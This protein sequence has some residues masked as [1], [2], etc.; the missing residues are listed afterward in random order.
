MPTPLSDGEF[1]EA[2][3]LAREKSDEVKQLYER[4]GKELTRLPAVQP[5]HRRRTTRGVI[6]SST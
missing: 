6:A 4:F 3:E 1:D 5:V 2:K